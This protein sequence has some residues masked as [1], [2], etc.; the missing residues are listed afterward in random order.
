M[1]NIL[2]ILCNSDTGLQTSDTRLFYRDVKPQISLFGNSFVAL[3]TK[4]ANLFADRHAFI[5]VQS[6]AIF[7]FQ[8]DVWSLVSEV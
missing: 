6:L 5:F 8:S 7:P 2:L 3:Y 4:S 1:G